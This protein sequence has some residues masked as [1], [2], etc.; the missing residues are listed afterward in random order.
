MFLE[1]PLNQAPLQSLMMCPAAAFP[2]FPVTKSS[3]FSLKKH[4]RGGTQPI[5]LRQSSC[6]FPLGGREYEKS[7]V[8]DFIFSKM[9]MGSKSWLSKTFLFLAAQICHRAI[10]KASIHRIWGLMKLDEPELESCLIQSPTE[11]REKLGE[12]ER[13][14]T[15]P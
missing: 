2:G 14:P 4:N 12:S 10:G 8:S 7:M 6:L 5:G 3:V 15:L 9:V 13:H 1:K 11:R